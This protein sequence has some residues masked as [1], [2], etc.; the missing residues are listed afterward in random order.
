[1]GPP[2]FSDGNRRAKGRRLGHGDPSM[3]P[4]PFSDGNSAESPG[5]PQPP[6]PFN[7]ATAFQ[8]WKRGAWCSP[9]SPART[10]N[11]ATAFQRWKL[12]LWSLWRQGRL[13]P[14][15]GPPPF[16]DGNLPDHGTFD[17]NNADLQWGHRLS[18]METG[19]TYARVLL[20]RYSLQWGHRLSAMETALCGSPPLWIHE[21]AV[22]S[23]RIGY[24]I[25]GRASVAQLGFAA[26]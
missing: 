14:S 19:L 25:N 26:P 16:S 17:R 3:G 4:P 11:G 5:P 8:R 2:P 21:K 7:G 15:M 12:A 20:A 13:G 22:F 9:S 24:R 18:A 6:P 10:F 23:T 1:M